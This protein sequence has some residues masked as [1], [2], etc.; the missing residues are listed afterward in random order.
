MTRLL[1]TCRSLV[2]LPDHGYQEATRVSQSTLL[3][4][5]SA[6]KYRRELTHT[7]CFASRP[8]QVQFSF[9]YHPRSM[10]LSIFSLQATTP[11]TTQAQSSARSQMPNANSELSWSVLVTVPRTLPLPVNARSLA[12]SKQ[13]GSE[14]QQRK[15][16]DRGL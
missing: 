14:R 5:P 10:K 15:D 11:P 13:G 6:R 16:G 7:Q 12:P 9:L 3:S 4:R 1:Q 8:H 2:G